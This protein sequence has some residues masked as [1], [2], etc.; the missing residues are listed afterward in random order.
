MI[1][2]I[3]SMRERYYSAEGYENNKKSQI[4]MLKRHYVDYSENDWVLWIVPELFQ[5]YFIK[6]L[7]ATIKIKKNDG[8]FIDIPPFLVRTPYPNKKIHQISMK[9]GRKRLYGI[10]LL[11]KTFEEISQISEVL[12]NWEIYSEGMLG[13]I[14]KNL[15]VKYNLEFKKDDKN[16]DYHFFTIFSKDQT[17]DDFGNDEFRK[18]EYYL[19]FDKA[20][21]LSGIINTES[22]WK[23]YIFDRYTFKVQ[24]ISD[25][26]INKLN[27]L[28][29]ILPN[30]E[31][32]KQL[33][34]IDDDIQWDIYYYEKTEVLISRYMA[35]F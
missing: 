33:C 16:K 26:E 31:K 28:E 32:I 8:N 34:F 30:E 2:E 35:N 21:N 25:E 12:I 29:E 27:K 3:E 18:D 1:K 4:E 9:S 20:F 13:F 22:E 24:E 10:P 7:I 5:K 19:E 11:F 17:Y 6:D 14:V 23:S 15:T